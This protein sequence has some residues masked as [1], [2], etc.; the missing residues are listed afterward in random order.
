MSVKETFL[1]LISYPTNSDPATG[2]TPSTPGQKVLGAH[3]VDLMKEMGIEDAYM[4]DTGRS[5]APSRTS[6]LLHSPPSP[7][8]GLSQ[9]GV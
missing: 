6:Q 1:D 4:S 2:V 7:L 5:S 8:P 9:F 3:I